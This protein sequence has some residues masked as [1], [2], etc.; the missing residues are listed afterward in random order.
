[1][2]TT[3]YSTSGNANVAPFRVV[4]G[5]IVDDDYSA[6]PAKSELTGVTS[7]D[8]TVLESD[9]VL[10]G[11]AEEI[12][13]DERKWDA[14]FAATSPE[15]LAKLEQRVLARMKNQG[16]KPLDFAGK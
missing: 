8:I 16:T 14:A 1:M 7:R 2:R 11:S 5:S 9:V 4:G 10:F 12:E 13:E 6:P 3:E 15:K